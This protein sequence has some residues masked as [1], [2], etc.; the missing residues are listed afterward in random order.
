M[1]ACLK[2]ISSTLRIICKPQSKK[3]YILTYV[4]SEDSNPIAYSRSLVR[5]F[6]GDIS[7][8]RDAKFLYADNDDL[9]CKLCSQPFRF[10]L[11]LHC[12]CC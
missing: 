9:D 11:F 12:R 5:T 6:T 8:S 7:D 10:S 4:H 2:I 1:L 3:M